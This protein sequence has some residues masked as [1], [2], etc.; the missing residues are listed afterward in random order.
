MKFTQ[1]NTPEGAVMTLDGSFTFNDFREFGT[2]LEALR[3]RPSCRH[4]LDLSRL[5]FLDSAALGMLL[6][7]EDELRSSGSSLTLRKPLG[8]IARL[9][10]MSAM[11]K[12][13]RI[14]H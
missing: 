4:T 14:E 2:M 6:I 10:E 8:S 7:A 5:E 9:L 12:V 11:H 3:A 13:F 1:Q